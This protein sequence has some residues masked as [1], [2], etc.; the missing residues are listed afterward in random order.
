MKINCRNT[1]KLTDFRP[2]CTSVWVII[3][4]VHVAPYNK[5]R[6]RQKHT[7]IIS[8]AMMTTTRLK[9][10]HILKKKHRGDT[11]RLLRLYGVFF[12]PLVRVICMC[13]GRFAVMVFARQPGHNRLL[14][15]GDIL[16]S[17]SHKGFGTRVRHNKW[18]TWV[19]MF[20]CCAMGVLCPGLALDSRCNLFLF[21]F[22]FV[23]CF[24][25]LL[26]I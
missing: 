21:N 15:K 26:F 1:T 23:L 14:Q 24:F 19:L 11:W 9:R 25:D 5:T 4:R 3:I 7:V 6:A 22:R 10:T 13:S 12:P 2:K 18:C 20:P 16:S 17:S 8:L